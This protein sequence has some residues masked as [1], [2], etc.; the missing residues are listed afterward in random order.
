MSERERERDEDRE[1]EAKKRESAEADPHG[2]TSFM[3]K[4]TMFV[5]A[6]ILALVVFYIVA[7]YYAY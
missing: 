4:E 3:K 1:R 6:V 7:I 2:S 5:V